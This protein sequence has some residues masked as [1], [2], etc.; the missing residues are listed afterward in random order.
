[1]IARINKRIV[2]TGLLALSFSIA[3]YAAPKE[4]AV[5]GIENAKIVVKSS[6]GLAAV[7][8]TAVLKFDYASCK[9]Q[10]F[11]LRI[12]KP[13]S[14]PTKLTVVSVD[15][16]FDCFG[17]AVLRSY[18]L[19]VSSDAKMGTSYVL[20]NTLPV[21]YTGAIQIPTKPIAPPPVTTMP[22]PVSEGG[23]LNE[24]ETE[25]KRKEGTDGFE[26]LSTLSKKDAA[27]MLNQ[28]SWDEVTEIEL[29]NAKA[30]ISNPESLTFQLNWTAP[31]N[32][33]TSVVI[34]PNKDN[35]KN[36]LSIVAWSEE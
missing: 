27:Q 24:L 5:S 12:S 31:S 20:T 35:C 8:P 9:N 15:G 16:M 22:V 33:G 25:I 30:L 2:T 11:S 18:T 34:V 17:P 6:G 21:E 28:A 29:A 26:S 10:N 13:K 4:V 19:Q 23:C 36:Y 7:Q 1:M 14:G 32:S 3:T